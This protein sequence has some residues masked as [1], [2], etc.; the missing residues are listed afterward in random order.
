[1]GKAY[2][3]YCYTNSK[4]GKKYV[5]CTQTTMQKRA[6]KE[7]ENYRGSPYFYSAIRKYGWDSFKGEVIK[8]GLTRA[9]AAEVEKEYIQ[10][11]NTMNPEFGYNLHKGGF[12]TKEYSEIY[13]KARAKRISDT[14]KEER[15][16]PEYRKIMADRMKRVWDDA[17]RRESMLK[18]RK[19][20]RPSGRKAISVRCVDTNEVFCSIASAARSLTVCPTTI[21]HGF[22]S[23]DYVRTYS[24]KLCKRVTIEKYCGPV[25][26][27][28]EKKKVNC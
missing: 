13:K 16:S 25:E 20:G 8:E 7:G 5:G 9:K 18:A 23:H 27:S 1:M 4:N 12:V 26:E 24:H 3:V 21:Q 17:E 22:L 6:G 15:K 28:T 14:L 11:Y 19:H 2:L 10:R